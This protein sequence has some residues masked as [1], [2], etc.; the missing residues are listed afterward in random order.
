M[1]EV[2]RNT[3]KRLAE[4]LYKVASYKEENLVKYILI[5]DGLRKSVNSICSMFFKIRIN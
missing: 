2:N 4:F 3:T 5:K 1:P